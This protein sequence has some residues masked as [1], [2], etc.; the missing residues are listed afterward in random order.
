M[1]D[2]V[3]EAEQAAEQAIEPDPCPGTGSVHVAV[4]NCPANLTTVA[5]GESPGWPICPRGTPVK[6]TTVADLTTLDKLTTPDSL[7]NLTTVKGTL[8]VP[9]SIVDVLL[10]A[11]EPAAALLY[12]R[13]YRLSHGY[14]NESCIVGLQKLATA[15]HTSQ[16]TVQRAIDYLER[17]RLIVR[18]GA[19]LGGRTRGLQFRVRVPGSLANLTTLDKTTTVGKMTTPDKMVKMTT[20]VNLASNKDDDLLNTNHHQS[21]EAL[22]FPQLPTTVPQEARVARRENDALLDRSEAGL[23]SVKQPRFDHLTQTVT[24]YTSVTRNPWLQ[25]DTVSYLQHHVDQVP[26]EKVK[27]VIQTVFERAE[28]RI[29]S[30]AYFVKEILATNDL[31]TLGGRRKALA[32]IIRRVRE[33]HMGL[34]SYAIADLVVDVKSACAREGVMFDNDLFNELIK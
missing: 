16:K 13:L 6:T 14:R 21:R 18:E 32:G 11:L 9:N 19:N 15:T 22:S 20:L 27:T 8:H 34:A 28:C 29:N 5:T 3:G 25:T 23:G 12:L 10:P 7:A 4:E 30:F 26:I 17:R 33:N 31:R 24:A 2:Q 1:L